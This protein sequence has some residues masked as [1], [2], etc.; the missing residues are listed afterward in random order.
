MKTR[1]TRK[2]G[3][4]SSISVRTDSRNELENRASTILEPTLEFR[5]SRE[6]VSGLTDHSSGRVD[7]F[8]SLVKFYLGFRSESIPPTIPVTHNAASFVKDVSSFAHAGSSF[9]GNTRSH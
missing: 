4:T 2:L 9:P 3:A 6:F 5:V 7:S 1:L 8:N